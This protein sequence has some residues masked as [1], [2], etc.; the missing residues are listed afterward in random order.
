MRRAMTVL[1]VAGSA[2][3]AGCTAATYDG[4]PG[5]AGGYG[6]DYGYG[7]GPAPVYAAPP[8]G[9]GYGPAYA[10]GVY[11]G[12]YDRGPGWYRGDDGAWRRRGWER[13]LLSC[14]R[15]RLRKAILSGSTRRRRLAI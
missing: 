1:V 9:Y 12:G 14:T 7:A 3:L 5:Y 8:V 10:G 2:G 15:A 4:S 13:N 6:Y 11:V